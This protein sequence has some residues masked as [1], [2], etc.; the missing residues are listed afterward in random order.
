MLVVFGGASGCV[1]KVLVDPF[2]LRL[3]WEIKC[4]FGMIVG[5]VTKFLERIS[6]SCLRLLLFGRQQGGERSWDVRFQ[7]DLND[8]EMESVAAFLHTVSHSSY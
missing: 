8:W 6:R 7:H 2:R 4:N 5:V 1:G 3:V